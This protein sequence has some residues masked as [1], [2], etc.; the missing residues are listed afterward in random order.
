[1]STMTKTQLVDENI[2]LR[3]QCEVLEGQLRAALS[4]QATKPAVR[5][6]EWDER[7]PG[8]FK[9]ALAEAKEHSG[10][11]QRKKQGVPS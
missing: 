11:V 2:R 8:D 10:R 3:A 9:R 5:V 1:M 6:F 4:K 7:I